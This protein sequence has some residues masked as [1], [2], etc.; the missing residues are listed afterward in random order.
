MR[1]LL[2][3]AAV[4]MPVSAFAQIGSPSGGSST[5]IASPPSLAPNV[6]PTQTAPVGSSSTSPN[7][8]PTRA[9]PVTAPGGGRA[10]PDPSPTQAAPVDVP[11]PG[12]T[13]RGT[14]GGAPPAAGA[15]TGRAAAPEAVA[16]AEAIE[17]ARPARRGCGR[18]R[19][20]CGP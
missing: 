4:A 19:S 2:I 11:P 20:A 15:G 5:G 12:G 10:R 18:A 3:A 8:S 1:A 9:A 7:V 14:L 17:S 13:R 6:S 16:E